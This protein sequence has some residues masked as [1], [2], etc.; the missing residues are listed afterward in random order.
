[1]LQGRLF[2]R[3]E[4]HYFYCQTFYEMKAISLNL[5]FKLF[6]EPSIAH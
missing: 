4:C 5:S 6:S 3:S 2:N 1:M